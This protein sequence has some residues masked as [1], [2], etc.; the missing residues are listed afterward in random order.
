[1]T[2]PTLSEADLASILARAGLSLD[3]E[4]VRALLPGAAIMLALIEQVRAPLP[5][6]AEP[7]VAFKADQ[8]R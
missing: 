4:Q 1:M 6:E 2:E 8:G 3:P 5:R 7:A